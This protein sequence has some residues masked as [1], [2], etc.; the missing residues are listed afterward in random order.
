MKKNEKRILQEEVENY[1]RSFSVRKKELAK[2]LGISP[3]ALSHW[4]HFR[5]TFS[6][7]RLNKIVSI[8]DSK[9]L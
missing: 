1:C 8:I 4:L 5:T 6:D 2:Q 9:K 7:E 3:V